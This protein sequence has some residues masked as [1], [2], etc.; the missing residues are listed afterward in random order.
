MQKS[1]LR[2][3]SLARKCI[4]E[5]NSISRTLITP[6]AYLVMWRSINAFKTK[7]H[8]RIDMWSP[9]FKLIAFK[10]TAT[11]EPANRSFDIMAICFEKKITFT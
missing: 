4:V 11:S 9:I 2:K 7:V 5:N 6:K 10:A 8:K 3:G 1:H